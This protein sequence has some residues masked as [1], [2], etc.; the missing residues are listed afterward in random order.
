MFIY[1]LFSFSANSMSVE[2]TQKYCRG[3]ASQ[4][5][6]M[7]NTGDLL[8]ANTIKTI[9]DMGYLNCIDFQ[10]H[11]KRR[12][13]AGATVEELSSLYALVLGFANDKISLQDGV[14][15]FLKWADGNPNLGK[16]NIAEH[17]YAYLSQPFP[18]KI[19]D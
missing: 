7:Q 14:I 17:A 2:D 19:K 3:Y 4:G 9:M 18:C 8:C 1:P 10:K 5:F 12:G 11:I 6:E 15:S 13:E 16:T